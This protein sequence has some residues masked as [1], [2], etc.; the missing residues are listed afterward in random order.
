MKRMLLVALLCLVGGCSDYS[1]KPAG[2]SIATAV[3]AFKQRNGL[4]PQRLEELVPTFL[5]ALPKGGKYF[6]ITYAPEPDRMQCWVAY[7]VHRD[8]LE[9]YDCRK[10]VWGNVEIEDSHVFRHPNAQFIK[11]EV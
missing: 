9:E 1:L 7:Q 6:A 5:P 4:Y 8:R 3:Q 2:E 11:P 10:A